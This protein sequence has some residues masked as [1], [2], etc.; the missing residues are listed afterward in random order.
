[1][2]EYLQ[3][4]GWSEILHD[5]T[6]ARV[7]LDIVARSPR[8]ILTIVEVKMQSPRAIAFLSR[9]QNQRLLRAASVLA[10]CEPVQLVLALVESSR[11]RLLP[12]DA[13]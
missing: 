5:V 3:Q 11:L 12:V 2:C 9:T 4:Q 7:Q 1:M 6:C 10:Q 13:I 8:G